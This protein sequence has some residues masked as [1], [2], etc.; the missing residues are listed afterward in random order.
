LLHLS[1]GFDDTALKAFKALQ[2]E[3]TGVWAISDAL[4]GIHCAALGDPE[5]AV[6]KE[7]KGSMIWSPLSNL[8]LYGETAKVGSAREHEVPIALGSDWSP[9]GSKNL[10]HELKVAKVVNEK[11]GYGFSDADIVGLATSGP[12]S[13]VKWGNAVGSIEAGKRADMTVILAPAATDAYTAIIGARETNVELVI[14]DGNATV[15]TP[16]LMTAL[17]ANGETLTVGGQKRVINY[18]KPDPD[19]VPITYAHAVQVLTDAL[20]NLPAIPKAPPQLMQALGA[21]PAHTWSLALDEQHETGFALRPMLEFE[22]MPTGPDANRLALAAVAAVPIGPVPLDK[23]SVP[24]DPDY[25]A[26]IQG[27]MNIPEDIKDGLK[28]FYP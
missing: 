11:R 2:N 14:I 3:Q 27:Q 17:G 4:A 1:E 5:F 7:H 16:A 23:V 19:I 25:A 10:M 8:M 22:G 24:D 15:G 13:I 26:K 9:S 6:M 18:G 21:K 20:A 28:A 12:A